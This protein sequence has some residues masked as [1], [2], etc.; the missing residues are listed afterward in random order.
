MVDAESEP[1]QSTA[2]PSSSRDNGELTTTHDHSAGPSSTRTPTSPRSRSRSASYSPASSRRGTKRP[3]SFSPVPEEDP[4]A[5]SHSTLESGIDPDPAQSVKKPRAAD[6]DARR[7]G[8]RLFGV[9]TSTLSQFKR[10]SESTRAASAAQKRA[11]IEARL[12]AKLEH[13]SKAIDSTERRRSLVWEARALAEQIAAGDAQ[14]KTLR[15]M[16][17]RMASFLYTPTP[18]SHRSTRSQSKGEHRLATEIPTSVTPMARVDDEDGGYAV[19]F[20]P[21]RTLPEQE[22]LLNAQEDDVD[23]RIDRFDDAW[24]DER[25]GL[26]EELERVKTRIRLL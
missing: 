11:E 13:T 23:D 10:E 1:P 5:P 20:L 18:A 9:L 12:A 25:R 3:S 2:G 8:Q 4:P 24:D 19:Y 26:C 21:G 7:R 14:R 17:R 22:D 16:K 15:S 6:P